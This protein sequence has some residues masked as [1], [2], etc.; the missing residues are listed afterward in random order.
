MV[1]GGA[2]RRVLLLIGVNVPRTKK[3]G[4]RERSTDGLYLVHRLRHTLHYHYI[5]ADGAAIE[6]PDASYIPIRFQLMTEMDRVVRNCVVV[7]IKQNTLGIQIEAAYQSAALHSPSREQHPVS[8]AEV[9]TH[10]QRQFMQYLRTGAWVHAIDLPDVARLISNGWI[11]RDG[12][13]SGTS[14]RISMSGLAAKTV[15]VQIARK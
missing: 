8:T 15:P 3:I 13:G 4:A 12:E 10:P 1:Q 7:W 11:E 9:P 6:V 14:Y 2:H 5:S